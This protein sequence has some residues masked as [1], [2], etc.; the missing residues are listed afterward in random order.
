MTAT[1]IDLFAGAGGL[2]LGLEA[3]GFDSVLAVEASVM[4]AET[5]F[6]NFVDRDM[7]AWDQ[8][9]R[10]ADLEAQIGRGVAVCKTS[11]VLGQIEAVHRL[12]NGQRLDLLAGGPP[13]QG[14]SL[15]G[16]RDPADQRNQL[17][18]EFLRFVDELKPRAVLIE[19]VV[20]IGL[21]FTRIPGTAPL[22][23]LRDA[24][25][26]KGY[27]A[28]ILEVNSRD[29][30]VPQYRPRVMIAALGLD[31]VQRLR[32]DVPLERLH[33]L[34][35]ERWS[36][37]RPSLAP[38]LPLLEMPA[39]G[40]PLLAP[41]AFL[42]ESRPTVSDALDDLDGYS[43]APSG[44]VR[45]LNERL[46]PSAGQDP[47]GPGNHVLRRHSPRT[48]LRFRLHLALTRYGI[49]G[50]IFS[51]GSR[52]SRDEARER[53]L[54]ILRQSCVPA[55][56]VFEGAPIRDPDTGADIG[57][58]HQTLVDAL[59]R[60]STLKHS[61]RAL[62]GDQPSPTLLSLPDDF[63]HHREPRTLTVREMAR[64]Q[65]FPDTFR[66]YSKETTGGK[67]RKTEVPQYTQVG[68]AVPP[69][70]AY[71]VGMRL[72]ELLSGSAAAREHSELVEAA[73]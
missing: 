19:N 51:L 71:R 18:F 20:G 8:H 55:P 29:F 26:E 46:R 60:L 44:Y 6:R 5:Y 24:L 36:S 53:L 15:A 16:M 2:S 22:E 30:G 9:R 32:P 62:V 47:G 66:F 12:L 54:Q 31:D 61:Q 21:S 13:C 70:M 69:L 48:M 14:F 27:L 49:K 34:S 65:S 40:Q 35:T 67:K 73:P 4:A 45:R 64:L 37:S 41:V 57:H 58:N 56:L 1:L 42:D 33:E 23:Q 52:V 11:A 17:P 63:V 25:R 28:Q 3:T 59:L 50:N 68:N 43:H 10:D 39:F 72:L 7:A 38:Q